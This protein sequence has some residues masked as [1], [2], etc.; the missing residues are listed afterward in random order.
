MK[1]SMTSTLCL[2]TAT[3][4][5]AYYLA[6]HQLATDP[7]EQTITVT[8]Q[9]S[10]SGGLEAGA[11]VTLRGVRV[12]AVHAVVPHADSVTIELSLRVSTS[13]PASA[14]FVIE[15]ASAIGEQYLD[16]RPSAAA[17]PYLTDGA[18]LPPGR[19]SVPVS[20]GRA[21][22][23]AGMLVD[24]IDPGAVA[25]IARFVNDVTAGSGRDDARKLADIATL[26]DRALRDQ[27]TT[28]ADLRTHLDRLLTLGSANTPEL[29]H[30][31]TSVRELAQVWPLLA[32]LFPAVAEGLSDN[33]HKAALLIDG[34][35]PRAL[36]VVADL[37]TI[38]DRATPD[39]Y[40]RPGAISPIDAG[41]FTDLLLMVFPDSGRMQIPAPGPTK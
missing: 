1:S 14:P 27:R 9:L 22:E 3:L 30:L 33:G 38:V 8:A 24:S 28:F 16:F 25:T 29:A 19:G 5:T 39:S 41:A 13:I 21:T 37:A 35:A 32:S 23:T 7:L 2:I 20:V 12:G 6:F 40:R 18:V 11:P 31:A 15:N 4:A 36:P 26:M 17:G 10:S 34:I